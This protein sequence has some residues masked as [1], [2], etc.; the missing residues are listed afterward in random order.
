MNMVKKIKER[1]KVTFNARN[2]EI[3]D[4]TPLALPAGMKKPESLHDQIRRLIKSERLQQALSAQGYETEEEAN[5]FDVGDDYDPSTPYEEQFHGEFDQISEAVKAER[6]LAEKKRNAP[7]KKHK[8]LEEERPAP[9]KAHK[10]SADADEDE[11]D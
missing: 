3:L 8:N 4:P 11:Q 2:E 1:F 6:K 5:D 9:K 10:K 7:P